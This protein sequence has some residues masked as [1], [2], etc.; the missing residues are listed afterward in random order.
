LVHPHR[1]WQGPDGDKR[2]KL[3]SVGLLNGEQVGA[4]EPWAFPGQDGP[5]SPAKTDAD[6]RAEELYLNLLGRLTL[7]KGSASLWAPAQAER[8]L[9]SPAKTKPKP[10]KSG[11]KHLQTHKTG[12]LPQAEF[13]SKSTPLTAAGQSMSEQFNGR[14]HAAEGAV[15]NDRTYARRRAYARAGLVSGLSFCETA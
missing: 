9:Y 11:S 7:S 5:P 3:V 14:N 10:P 12:F 2:F 1:S 15:E 13:A 4:I 6:R 8:Q